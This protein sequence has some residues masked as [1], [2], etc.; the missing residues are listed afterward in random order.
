M[1]GYEKQLQKFET[2]FG[3]IMSKEL[4]GPCEK[5]AR[6]L[7]SP[8]YSATGTKQAAEALCQTMVDL[9]TEDGFDRVFDETQNA[10]KRLGLQKS[11]PAVAGR[12]KPPTRFEQSNKPASPVVLDARTNLRKEFFAAVDCVIFRHE[13]S[14]R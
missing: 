2:L 3:L 10:A 7:Q 11:E 9:R 6:A 12:V 14:V 5:L 8:K 4:F 13:K 1:R